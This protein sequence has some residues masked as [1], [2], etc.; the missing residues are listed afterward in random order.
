MPH[1]LR[2]SAWYLALVAIL[3][4][5]ALPDGWM[6]VADAAG[7]TSIVICTGHGPLAAPIHSRKQAPLPGRS[8]D[9]CPFA[10][11]AHFSPPA[12]FALLP[13]PIL[14]S[15]ETDPAAYAWI[16]FTSRPLGNHN[17]R[18]PPGFA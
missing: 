17:A 7:G 1:S 12:L 2:I 9:V 11:A 13:A 3:L 5:A 18:A 10:A 16:A 6:P 14:N 15:Q 4:R 8:S